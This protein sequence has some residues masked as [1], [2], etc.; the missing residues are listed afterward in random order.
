MKDQKSKSGS[1]MEKYE[2]SNG[3]KVAIFDSKFVE[4]CAKNILNS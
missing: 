2:I 4:S 3:K 1:N